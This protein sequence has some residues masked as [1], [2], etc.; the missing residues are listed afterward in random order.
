MCL[1]EFDPLVGKAFSLS[2]ICGVVEFKFQSCPDVF[3]IRKYA[4]TPDS[5]PREL[6]HPTALGA[7][8]GTVNRRLQLMYLCIFAVIVL[9]NDIRKKQKVSGQYCLSAWKE[10]WMSSEW[11]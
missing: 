9:I 8:F 10:S 5:L 3:L 4:P 7:S 2:V 6:A 11:P 1:D